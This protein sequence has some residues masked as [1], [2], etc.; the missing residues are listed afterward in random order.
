MR[1]SEEPRA[2]TEEMEVKGSNFR[3]GPWY[4]YISSGGLCGVRNDF[5]F[6]SQ[7]CKEDFISNIFI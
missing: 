4:P 5:L 1:Q 2:L 6:W 3:D 7:I